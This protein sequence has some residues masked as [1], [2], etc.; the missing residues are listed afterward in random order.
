M[1]NLLFLLLPF[2]CNAQYYELRVYHCN[3]GKLETL[4]TR[5]RD[6]TTKLFEKHG[7]RNEGYWIPAQGNEQVL[8]Y[9]LSYPSKEDREASWKGFMA[10]PVWQEVA[11]KSE[12]NGKI[13][14]KIDSYFMTENKDLS[15]NQ[16]SL[17]SNGIF[18][19][20]I[21]D[22]LPDQYARIVKRFKDH[23]QSLFE[24]QGMINMMYYDTEKNELLYL[25]SH[26]SLEA[27][28]KAWKG[29]RSDPAWLKVKDD[30]EKPGPIVKEVHSIFLKP[31]DFSAI[32]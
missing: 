8:Y 14:N 6:H 16:F 19:L 17:P 2:F 27:A 20:R 12:E 13:I 32:K 5:F 22:I 10:D 23:T 28:E 31:T 29:F 9:I 4:L 3:E 7:M 1:K 26:T 21:Y 24:K 11:R 15:R 30:S 25:L 18:E